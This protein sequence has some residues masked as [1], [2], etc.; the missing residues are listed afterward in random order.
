MKERETALTEAGQYIAAVQEEM[1]NNSLERQ[2]LISELNQ[3]QSRCYSLAKE[4]ERMQSKTFDIHVI[5]PKDSTPVRE[6]HHQMNT[7]SPSPLSPQRYPK[8]QPQQQSD[9]QPQC[10]FF[11]VPL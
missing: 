9:S 2:Q 7:N 10:G 1:H 3:A 6:T 4:L 5:T 11:C 8:P